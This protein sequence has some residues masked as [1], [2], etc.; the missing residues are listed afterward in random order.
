MA[1]YT[2]RCR[3]CEQKVTVE[4]LMSGPHP[5]H[6]EGC[7]GELARVFDSQAEVIYRTTGFTRTD[8]RFETNPA[9]I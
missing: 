5:T 3:K 1:L 2:F 7:G 6:H 4:H 9:D 8:R